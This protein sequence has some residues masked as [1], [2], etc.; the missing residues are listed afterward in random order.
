MGTELQIDADHVYAEPNDVPNLQIVGMVHIFFL[1][2]VHFVHCFIDAQL[3]KLEK[4]YGCVLSQVSV[5]G[6]LILGKP[7]QKV[8]W[9]VPTRLEAISLLIRMIM[10]CSSE[11]NPCASSSK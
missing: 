8:H 6:V 4:K 7:Y 11:W 3:Q 10:I 1:F 9:K 5:F 2:M